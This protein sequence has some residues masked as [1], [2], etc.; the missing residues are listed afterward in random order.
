VLRVGQRSSILDRLLHRRHTRFW[1]F[2]TAWN[3]RSNWLPLWRNAARQRRLERLCSDVVSGA[4]VA[5]DLAWLPEPSLLV[6]GMAPGRAVR[7]ARLFGQ[8]AILAG[9]RGRPARLLWCWPG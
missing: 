3:P 1:A 4:G 9:A 5:A 6:L 2:L 7:L 8:N